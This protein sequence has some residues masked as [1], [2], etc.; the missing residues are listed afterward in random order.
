MIMIIGLNSWE[1]SHRSAI[2]EYQRPK[3]QDINFN[4]AAGWDKYPNVSNK[5]S[6]EMIK[7]IAE[8]DDMNVLERKLDIIDRQY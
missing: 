2:L 7:S 5:H 6:E 1:I 4:N 8:I 3:M